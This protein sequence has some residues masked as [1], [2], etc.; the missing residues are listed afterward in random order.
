MKSIMEKKYAE[1]V[2]QLVNGL[3]QVKGLVN[4]YLLGDEFYNIDLL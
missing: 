1:A 3:A 4:D 2:C